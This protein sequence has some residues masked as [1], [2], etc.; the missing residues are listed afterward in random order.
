MDIKLTDEEIQILIDETKVLPDDFRDRLELK[1]KRGHK[2]SQL[3]VVG[4]KGSKFRIILRQSSFDAFDF[5][6]ILAYQI[7]KTNIIWVCFIYL[8]RVP[9]V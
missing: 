4:E 6:V 3:S 5:S 8:K 2:E 7:P 1:A 9:S